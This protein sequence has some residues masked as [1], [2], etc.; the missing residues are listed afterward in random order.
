[1]AEKYAG[2]AQDATTQSGGAVKDIRATD[3]VKA[4]EYNL[5]VSTKLPKVT[6]PPM[7]LIVYYLRL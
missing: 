6:K 2:H 4:V 1:M 5:R 3:S 7:M